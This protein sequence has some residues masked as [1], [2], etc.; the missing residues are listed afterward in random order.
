MANPLGSRMTT[1]EYV[2]YLE[3]QVSDY[4]GT[5]EDGLQPEIARLREENARLNQELDAAREI[6]RT[7]ERQQHIGRA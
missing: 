2:T 7:M 4:K 6:I 1:G 5:V 3:K